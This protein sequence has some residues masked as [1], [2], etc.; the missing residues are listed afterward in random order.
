MKSFC[1][2][3]RL[4]GFRS[5]WASATDDR[6]KSIKNTYRII[7]LPFYIGNQSI[8]LSSAHPSKRN[9]LLLPFALRGLSIR[10][11]IRRCLKRQLAHS[12][13]WNIICMMVYI[14]TAHSTIMPIRMYLSSVFGLRIAATQP[15]SSHPSASLYLRCPI[16]ICTCD[17]RHQVLLTQQQQQHHHHSSIGYGYGS[18][19]Q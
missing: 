3:L 14:P 7:C 17:P 19:T 2:E 16:H 10:R 5:G 15:T 6:R 8:T 1:L 4:K 11:H 12:C 13:L 18:T 9:E